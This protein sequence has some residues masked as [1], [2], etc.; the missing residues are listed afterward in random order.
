[1]H[2]LLL[3]NFSQSNME[4]IKCKE[5]K[6]WIYKESKEDKRRNLEILLLNFGFYSKNAGSWINKSSLKELIR[7]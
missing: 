5:Y 6:I 3:D 4:V 2:W 1:M 7:V